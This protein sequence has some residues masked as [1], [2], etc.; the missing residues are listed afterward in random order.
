MRPMTNFV[1][2]CKRVNKRGK[3]TRN[4]PYVIS[5]YICIGGEQLRWTSAGEYIWSRQ[6]IRRVG[7]IEGADEDDESGFRRKASGTNLAGHAVSSVGRGKKQRE[8]RSLENAWE[9]VGRLVVRHRS[10]RSRP[11][12]CARNSMARPST[13]SGLRPARTPPSSMRGVRAWWRYWRW[14]SAWRSTGA[15]EA[16]GGHLRGVAA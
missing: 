5:V 4:V 8:E 9:S 2:R 7:L 13:S 11:F 16:R 12:P 14:G 6:Q 10:C 15:M 1:L 3:T